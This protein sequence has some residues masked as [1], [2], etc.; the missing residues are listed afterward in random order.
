[1]SSEFFKFIKFFIF[2]FYREPAAL[3]I[4]T[5][6]NILFESVEFFLQIPSPQWTPLPLANGPHCQA[7][8]EANFHRQAIA[9]AG[10]TR[11]TESGKNFLPLSV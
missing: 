11:I 1:M 5:Y 8:S 4:A 7:H 9:H 10:H 3:N 6:K 2:Y